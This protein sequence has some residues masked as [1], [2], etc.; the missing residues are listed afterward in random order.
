MGRVARVSLAAALWGV[1]GLCALS[2]SV[3]YHAGLPITREIVRRTLQDFLSGEMS[4]ELRI[5]RIDELGTDRVVVRHVQVFDPDGVRVAVGD[6]VVLVPDLAA[7]RQGVLRFAS[8][9]L[10]GGTV[11][12]IDG[13][14]G[15][16]TFILAF[17]PADRT[18]STLPPLHAIVDGM[19]IEHVTLYG[20]VLGLEG[21]R[22]EDLRATGRLEVERQVAVSVFSATGR[23]VRPFPFTGHVDHFDAEIHTDVARGLRIHARGRTERADG[24]GDVLSVNVSFRQPDGAAEDAPQE[25]HVLVHGSPAR[26][27]LLSELGFDW[28]RLFTGHIDGYYRLRGPVDDLTMGLW[29]ETSGGHVA[30]TGRIHEGRVSVEGRSDGVDLARIV[31]DAPNLR[32]GGRARLEVDATQEGAPPGLHL[33]IEPFVWDRWAVPTFTVDGAIEEDRVR[34]DRVEAPHANGGVTGSGVVG[35]DGRVDLHVRG[36]I[37]QIAADPNIRRLVPGA[38]GSLSGDVHVVAGGSEGSRFSL[39][40]S[41]TLGNLRYGPLSAQRLRFRGHAGGNT[42]RPAVRA[43]IDGEAV[44]V[45]GYD[46]GAPDLEVTG[47]PRSYEASGTFTAPGD[48]QLTMHATVQAEGRRF[49]VDADRIEFAVGDRVWRGAAEHVDYDPNRSVEVRRVVLASGSQRLEAHGIYRIHGPEEI[50]AQLQD[51]D[52]EALRALMGPSAPD[53]AGRLDTH[54]SLSG[55]IERP[56]VILEGSLRQGTVLGISDI[57]ALYAFAYENG[58]LTVDGSVDL[59]D[60]GS[61]LLNGTGMIDPGIPDPMEALEGG[62]YDLQ[63]TVEEV[64]LELARTMGRDRVPEMTGR[65]GGA[66]HMNGPIFAPSFEGNLTVPE[67]GL[68]E[69]PTLGLATAFTYDNGV[70]VVRVVTSDAT[71]ELADGEGSLVVDL[72]NLIRNPDEVVASLESLPWR[73]SVRMPARLLS[74]LPEPIRKRIP[75]AIHPVRAAVSGTFAGGGFQTRGDLHVNASWE[76]DVARLFCGGQAPHGTIDAHLEDGI[77]RAEARAFLAGQRV[78]QIQASAETPVD[79]WLAA[80]DVPDMP[81]VSARGFLNNAPMHSLP[82][83]CRFARGPLTAT[84]QTE[85]LFTD[86]PHARVE[87]HS[88]SVQIVRTSPVRVDVEMAIRD[89]AIDANGTIAGW[90]GERADVT[91][92]FP[93]A[94]D[95]ASPFPRGAD[96]DVELRADFESAP[97][98]PFL[99]WM[100]QLDEVSGYMAGRLEALGTLDRLRAEG[101]V[102]VHDGYLEIAGLGQHLT[103]VGG[104][105]VLHG[106]WAELRGVTARDGDGR[107]AINGGVGFDGYRPARARL[108][109]NMSPFPVRQ[110]GTL[111]ATLTGQASVQADLVTEGADVHVAVQRLSVRLSDDASRSVQSLESHPDIIVLGEEPDE[112]V[113]DAPYPIR[114]RVDARAP[115]WVRRTD[116]AAQ[117]RAE[118]DALWIDPDLLIGG[119]LEIRR[120]FFDVF[121]KRFDVDRGTMNFTRQP[122]L[123]PEVNLV[124]THTL[125]APANTHVTVTVT[126]TL[127]TPGIDFSTDHPSCMTRPEVIQLLITGSCERSD[128]ASSLDQAQVEGQAMSFLAGALAGLG[129]LWARGELGELLPDIAIESGDQAFRSTRIRAGFRADDFIPVFLRDWVHGAYVEG[130]LAAEPGTAESGAEPSAG[131]AVT[132]GFMLE[133]QFPHSFVG[134]LRYQAP[135]SAGLD[136][137]WEP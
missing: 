69:W 41:A 26:A 1:V 61:F 11:R 89:G 30:M 29:A 120:G 108:S 99:A 5:G 19:A 57:T 83:L 112:V 60:R 92:R 71:G 104:T 80:A 82:G 6:R 65:V 77:T 134:T 32:V 90:S 31:T 68:P 75:E 137:T 38:R 94:W 84:F 54:L 35:F 13:R 107:I 36:R 16:S 59:G 27:R 70:L 23:V 12:L 103:D 7:A 118:I 53:V 96:G 115:F 73:F 88:P 37:P 79:E 72:A 101:E 8:A 114:I 9:R 49:I 42:S 113:D 123:N 51:F 63:L 102:E 129:T 78:A 34:V 125:R 10:S 130:Q 66:V 20:D 74:E 97:I 55:D 122:E 109:L 58:N 136:V 133:L 47:G 64:T 124:A 2:A 85:G 128:Q 48:R 25:L 21:L 110:E 91:A 95:G 100:P 98:A 127:N 131:S 15:L 44:T 126:G 135:S 111:M 87:L 18:P 24:P 33:E 93:I 14:G 52:L 116:F 40:G 132:G 22:V 45:W 17:E 62:I 67:L 50:D 56:T 121:G 76:G 28:G 46:L 86:A 39:D 43:R 3:L 105:V 81:A 117:V 4:G 119:Y 106:N